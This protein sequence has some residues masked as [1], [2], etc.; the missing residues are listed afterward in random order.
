MNKRARVEHGL[1]TSFVMS[2]A[3]RG[4]FNAGPSPPQQQV[5][6]VSRAV[7]H[8][9]DSMCSCISRTACIP[10]Q[11]VPVKRRLLD[12]NVA[13]ATHHYNAPLTCAASHGGMLWGAS[14]V[15]RVPLQHLV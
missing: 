12:E 4:L 15:Q 1:K 14:A 13:W 3:S 11:H 5:R 7:S 9:M 2:V 6:G 10:T 8:P